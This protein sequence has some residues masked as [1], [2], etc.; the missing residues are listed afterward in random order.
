[1]AFDYA[2]RNLFGPPAVFASLAAMADLFYCN[3]VDGMR[4]S[5]WVLYFRMMDALKKSEPIG[6]LLDILRSLRKLFYGDD[7]YLALYESAGE[8]YNQVSALNDR[9]DDLSFLG[10]RSFDE[11][12]KISAIG[13]TDMISACSEET[14]MTF[15]EI[16]DR[17]F[18]STRRWCLIVITGAP[19][20]PLPCFPRMV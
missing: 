2:C 5:F 6:V 3:P 7:A 9:G 8:L 11:D 19:E 18:F 16:R 17:I 14:D 10:L 12:K 13:I 20:K 15:D 1:M 4:E